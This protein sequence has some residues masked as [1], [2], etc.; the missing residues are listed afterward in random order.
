M[1]SRNLFKIF[2]SLTV[3]ALVL[4]WAINRAFTEKGYPDIRTAKKDDAGWHLFVDD[5][6]IS[7]SVNIAQTLHQPEK[8]PSNP[9]IRGDVPW[10]IAPYC[11]GSVIYDKR[12][13]VFKFWYQSYNFGE[14]VPVRTPVLYALSRDGI[15]WERPGLHLF[16][17]HGSDANNII[18]NNYGYHDLYSP[19]VIKDTLETD[20]AKRYKMVWWDFP[21][22]KEGYRDEGMCVAF[23]PDGI[24]WKKYV[25]N[26][27]LHA[28][29]SEH[30]ISDVMSLIHDKRTGKYV[31][32]S[33]GWKNIDTPDEF[34]QIV[35]TESD[36]FIHWS[37][38]QPVITHEHNLADPQSYGMSVSRM[39]SLYLGLI[40][41]YKKPGDETIDIQLTVSH[42]NLYWSRVCGQKTF[43]PL[44]PK[45]SWDAG[46]LFAAPMFNHGDKT[47]IYYSAWD[48]AHNE[49]ERDS[50]IGLAWLKKNRFVSLDAKESKKASVTTYT[51]KNAA[52]P[53]L[54]NADAENGYIIAELLDV[55]GN[56]IP[57]YKAGECIPVQDD[58]I[59]QVVKWKKNSELPESRLF[60]IRFILK[61]ASLFG[62]YAGEDAE[63]VK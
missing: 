50:G 20:P 61:N 48:G 60:R 32:Y 46:M 42:D 16:K 8:Y 40:S 27:V 4:V 19:S 63:R 17:Y 30:S 38:P 34:R 1:K 47:L 10:E 51:I 18:L 28:K 43:L 37:E 31:V 12:D 23:S 26:P 29:K 62:F 44:G 13:T 41:I 53:L 39:G 35:R 54:V 45:G 56:V 22:G 7:D 15:R 24:H 6:W 52:G 11:F 2:I 33:K 58:N 55:S 21:L 5:Y 36:D 9:V 14:P 59:L 57:G 49:K 25:V 3:I